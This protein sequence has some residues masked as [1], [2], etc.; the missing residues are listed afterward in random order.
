MKIADY[1]AV[2]MDELTKEYLFTYADFK[3]VVN[4]KKVA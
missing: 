2:T 1:I 4:K 3:L